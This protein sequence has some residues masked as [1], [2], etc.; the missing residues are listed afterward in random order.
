MVSCFFGEDQEAFTLTGHVFVFKLVVV[1]SKATMQGIERLL[2]FYL[3]DTLFKKTGCLC[4][5]S[6]KTVKHN[7]TAKDV[8]LTHTYTDQKLKIAHV[9]CSSTFFL[10]SKMTEMR[11]E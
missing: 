11:D 2:F 10:S 4:R 9:G 6:K 8:H 7:A 3:L 1:H 5:V